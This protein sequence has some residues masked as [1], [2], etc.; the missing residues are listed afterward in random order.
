MR[1]ARPATLL[2]KRQRAY[3]QQLKD[4]AAAH[5][6]ADSTELTQLHD[7]S[8]LRNHSSLSDRFLSSGDPLQNS[9]PQEVTHI[10]RI[11]R[12]AGLLWQYKVVTIAAALTVFAA[13]VIISRPF[14][15]KSTGVATPGRHARPLRFAAVMTDGSLCGITTRRPPASAT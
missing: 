1:D 13:V 12:V 5:P 10:T 7:S 9:V 2:E 8:P 3:E 14:S 6:L 11:N 4:K 15:E